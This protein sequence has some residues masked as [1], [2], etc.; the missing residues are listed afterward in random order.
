VVFARVV[1][2]PNSLAEAL[3]RVFYIGTRSGPI[4]ADA[5]MA[6]YAPSRRGMAQNGRPPSVNSRGTRVGSTFVQAVQADDTHASLGIRY[7]ERARQRLWRRYIQPGNPTVRLCVCE[8][9][10]HIATLARL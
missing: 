7:G 8:Q 1:G 9:P 6:R 2:Y 5:D 4:A 3:N 10:L